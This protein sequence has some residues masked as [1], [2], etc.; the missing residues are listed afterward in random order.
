MLQ[1]LR[2]KFANV[3]IQAV[4]ARSRLQDPRDGECPIISGEPRVN[5]RHASVC[6]SV[7]R[8]LLQRICS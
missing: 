5:I 4:L 7:V 8:V 3:R 6:G 2:D 1:R